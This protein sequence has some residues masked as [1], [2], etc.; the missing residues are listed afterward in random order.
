[1]GMTETA[2]PLWVQAASCEETIAPLLDAL[3]H[4]TEAASHRASAATCYEKSG[5]WGRAAN[6]CQA[7]L[8][9]PLS[10]RAKRELH[11]LLSRCLAKLD[12]GSKRTA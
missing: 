1:M 11:D 9:G 8:A 12:T 3:D 10:R 2:K 4:A 7:A 5:H 6:L